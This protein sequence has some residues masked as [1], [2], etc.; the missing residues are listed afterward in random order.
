MLTDPI[1]RALMTADGVQVDELKVLL[2]SVAKR[3]QTGD[4]KDTEE[5][6]HNSALR[7]AQRPNEILAE[8]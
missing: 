6:T 5:S 1:V 8:R 3:L 4:C 2:H 7:G